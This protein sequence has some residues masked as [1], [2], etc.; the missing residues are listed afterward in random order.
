MLDHAIASKDVDNKMFSIYLDKTVSFRSSIMFGSYD[1]EGVDPLNNMN[2]AETINGE[3]FDIPLA[4]IYI[5]KEEL[6][7]TATTVVMDP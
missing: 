7:L 5:N 2:I 4:S 3:V 6:S 1:I